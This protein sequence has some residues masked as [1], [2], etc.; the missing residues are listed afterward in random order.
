M[1]TICLLESGDDIIRALDPIRSQSNET[2]FINPATHR[3]VLESGCVPRIVGQE[4]T[5]SDFQI[6]ETVTVRDVVL[7]ALKSVNAQGNFEVC[8][9]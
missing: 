8:L 2:P 6:A 3:L 4:N 9:S 7:A 5:H 1:K